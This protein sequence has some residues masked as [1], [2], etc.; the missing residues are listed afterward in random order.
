MS[1]LIISSTLIDIDFKGAINLF[2]TL[3]RRPSEN[4]FEQDVD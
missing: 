1:N 3:S 4:Q 2:T